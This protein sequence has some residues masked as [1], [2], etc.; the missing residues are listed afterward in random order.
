MLEVSRSEIEKFVTSMF[1]YAGTEGF[2]SL[3]AFEEGNNKVF[4]I[5][6]AGL[7]GGLPG[8]I[9]AAEDDARRAANF[10]K[11]V[12]FCPPIAV[13]KDKDRAREI[14]IVA[15]FAL[16][17]EL[18]Q[19][20]TEAAAMLEKVL[21]PATLW[22]RSGGVW[23]D[24]ATA[25]IYDKLHGHW[26]LTKP[27]VGAELAKLKRARDLASRLV[28][29]DPS[30]QPVCHPFRWP[31]S[32]HRKGE[33]RPCEIETE[34]EREIDLDTALAALEAAPAA[35]ANGHAGANPFEAHGAAQQ[36]ERTGA[37]E[38]VEAIKAGVNLHDNLNRLAAKWVSAGMENAA[39]IAAL[40][41]LMHASTAPRDDRWRARHDDIPRA[42][43][44]AREKYH[45]PQ[46][47]EAHA[48][49]LP[50]MAWV[51]MSNWDNKPIPERE[52]AI[53][54]RSPANQ[55][56]LYSGHGGTG[57]SYTELLKNGAHVLGRD[58]YGTMPEL[59][60]AF[61][62]GAEDEE[63]EI[64]RRLAAVAAHYK[65]TFKDLVDGGLWVRCLLGEDATLCAATGKSGKV[66]V[67]KLYRQLHEAAGD[68]KPKNISIDTLS[69]AF[70]GN[71]IDRVEVY[72]FAMHMQ[73]LAMLA[74]GSVTVLSH[75]SLAGINSGSGISGS[76]AWHNAFRFRHYLKG[77][78]DDGEED[79]NSDLRELTF[80]KNQYGTLGEKVTLKYQDG[81]FLPLPGIST[82]DKT[83]RT[84]K[85]DEVFLDILRRWGAQGRN[86]SEK[87]TAHS[88]AP[89]AFALEQEAKKHSIRKGDLEAAMRRLFAANKI[90]VEP[91][92]K[93]SKGFTRLGVK[94]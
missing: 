33:P 11:K 12:V 40:Q 28:G 73:A 84:A 86:A 7:S 66:E 19:R 90:C 20:P 88:Y 72:G 4:R 38:L 45:Q 82:L 5:N 51:D 1:R 35:K 22:V 78:K 15:G 94:A 63:A 79:D 44:T 31:G 34:T 80:L 89:S 27:A 2:V 10:P 25:Q 69:R 59:G 81:L 70:A 16:S 9:D 41:G 74:G 77:V 68:I 53:L 29:G 71:E 64:H 18:D 65:V 50:R 87:K 57:K 46:E 67:T 75:P 3:R 83:G 48:A 55:A 6:G 85:V 30:G 17:V 54:D 8:L 91:Y 39:I 21:G 32:W 23:A 60:P 24:P 36:G 52:W 14:D 49:P 42:V 92:G 93:P 43:S 13:F 26:R 37:D 62:I 76:T 61:Y 58:W 56:G 47:Q